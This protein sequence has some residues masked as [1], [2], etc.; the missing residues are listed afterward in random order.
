MLSKF[1]CR[2]IVLV[3]YPVRESD[4]ILSL[5]TAEQG[6]LSAVGKGARNSKR[7]FMGG[8]DLFD[9]GRF[10]FQPLKGN[11]SLHLLCGFEDREVWLG[12]RKNLSC[13]ALA[14]FCLELTELFAAE[15]DLQG[16]KLFNP[17]QQL[18]RELN[19]TSHPT[20]QFA[21]ALR[22]ALIVLTLSGYDPLVSS[23]NR[24]GHQHFPRIDFQPSDNLLSLWQTL[25]GGHS[26][27]TTGRTHS[28]AVLDLADSLLLIINYVESLISKALRGH[29]SIIT[30]LLQ[31][32]REYQFTPS[33]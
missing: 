26:I 11:G 18:L 10:E 25:L 7:R 13:F 30:A 19:T 12:L 20:A 5:L 1:T 31:L 14:A 2:G 15:G 29:S 17:L 9:C 27:Q 16:A 6:K 8:V 3:K 24:S 22:Y 33:I 23:Q 4:L 28:E 21:A 32:R